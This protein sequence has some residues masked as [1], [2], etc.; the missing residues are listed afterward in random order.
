MK[1]LILVFAAVAISAGVFAQAGSTNK[2]ASP[3]NVD[4]TQSQNLQNQQDLNRI[5]N[6]NSQDL[7]RTQN[8]YGQNNSFD[9]SNT[10]GVYM[11]N[12]KMMKV[13]NGQKSAF[14][15]IDLTMSN[16]TKIMSDGTYIN[17]DGSKMTMTEGQHIDMEGN[18][19]PMNT[20]K[21][22]NMD[23]NRH[24]QNNPQNL[25]RTQNQNSQ[26]QQ[27]WNRSQ[28]QNTQ[29]QQNLNNTQNRNT[30][31]QQ[32]MNRTYDQNDSGDMSYCSNGVVMINGKMMELNNGIMTPFQDNDMTML[33][34]TKIKSDGAYSQKNGINLKL[35]EG[36][37]MDMAGNVL[38]PLQIDYS[39][40]SPKNSGDKSS[41]A[42][43]NTDKSGTRNVQ[44]SSTDKSSNGGTNN[45][46]TG[47]QSGTKSSTYNSSTDRTNN[48]TSGTQSGLKSSTDKSNSD[49]IVME[50]G[51]MMKVKNGQKSAFQDI[52]MTMS[53]GTKIMSDGTYINKDGS[54][55]T[56]TEGQHIDMEG[57]VITM[58]TNN[59]NM[60]YN[61]NR[62]LNPVDKSNSDGV[63][64]QNGKMM[65]VKNG[66]KSTLHDNEMTMNN[67]TKVMS[68]GT[69]ITKDG[70]KTKM[71]DGQH[72]DMEGNLVPV[73]TN[74]DKNMY[75]VPDTTRNREN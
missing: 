38:V 37:H 16:G 66:Q 71:K 20:N 43:T 65:K 42:K 48:T 7:N 39:K 32:D 52:D 21:D 62:Q 59:N 44:K 74:K 45:T 33:N 3:Q 28:N 54:K 64:M 58:N 25:N 19:I 13:K 29:S 31:N 5:H 49:G 26:N 1:K 34:G 30:Q 57:N 50:N 41:T 69:C 56:M 4:K 61:Q 53:N 73:N 14:Q 70:T 18:M 47:N 27:D 6:Q 9:H 10:D 8:Q 2:T 75:L 40:H 15:D 35:K 51:K 72:M 22:N 23:Y 46:S 67:G 55:M 63:F 17:K 24:D 11:E 68:D 12:G 60:N 36:Y